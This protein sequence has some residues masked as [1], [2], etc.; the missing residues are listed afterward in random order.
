MTVGAVRSSGRSGPGTVPAELPSDVY[1]F[2]GRAEELARLDALLDAPGS[3]SAVVISALSG[4][5]GVG[6]TALAVH[7][8][9]HVAERFPDGQLYVDLCGY[10]PDLPVRPEAALGGFLRALGVDGAAIPHGLAERAAYYRSLVAGRRVLV[11]LDN[12]YSTDQVRPL[13]PGTPSCLVVVTSR[14]SLTGLVVRHGAR[15]IDLDLLPPADAM[16]LLR[17]LVGELADAEPAATAAVAERCGRLPLALRVAVEFAA[18]RPAATMTELAE[19]L[20]DEQHR[21]DLLDSGVDSRT[22]VRAVFSWSYRHLPPPAARLFRLLG[23]FPGRDFDAPAAAALTSAEVGET[24]L[25][26]DRLVRAH[27]VQRTGQD[28][29]GLHDLLRSYAADLAGEDPEPDRRAARGNLLHYYVSTAA[30]AMDVLFPSE[31]HRRPRVA[32]HGGTPQFA[33]AAQARAWLDRERPQLVAV[34]AVEVGSGW[35]T[36]IGYLAMT[37]GRYLTTGAHLHDAFTVHSNALRVAVG[38]GDRLAEGAALN[39]LGLVLFRWD[40]NVEAIEHHQRA[41]AARR[42][43]G[44][45]VGESGTLLNLGL[46]YQALGRFADAL[47]HYRQAL[48]I[49]QEL[50][51]RNSVANCLCNLGFVHELLGRLDEAAEHAR[52]ALAVFLE[53]GNRINRAFPLNV[54]GKV[55]EKWGRYDEALAYHRE[56]LA[57]QRDGDHP[58]SAAY[59]RTRLASVLERQ[60]ECVEAA[61][62]LRLALDVA[63]E[64]G[65][66]AAQADARNVLG[67]VHR[68]DGRWAEAVEEHERAGTLA[69]AIGDRYQQARGLDGAAHAL[70]AKGDPDGARE[71]WTA[72]LAAFDELGVPDA[73][74]VRAALDDDLPP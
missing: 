37:I 28:R 53:V 65:D 62:Q 23:L 1:G 49:S 46:T 44:D 9:H 16:D 35:S 21:L 52:T 68:H 25:L 4:T 2:T 12:A 24:R 61:A 58:A 71:R 36:Y 72:A 73:A 41:L 40:R 11:V 20:A 7:W 34:T 47:D 18:L 10:D 56:A 31:R 5:A 50:G 70:R 69:A 63:E 22:A 48:A 54:L 15:R 55:H 43:V 30:A 14:D 51:D 74:T 66:V 38:R 59:T 67:A 13:L 60:G 33:D 64:I 6:K 39:H 19:E 32:R 27:L 57:L 45:R 42:E 29:F 26:L 3:A 17:C 8:A